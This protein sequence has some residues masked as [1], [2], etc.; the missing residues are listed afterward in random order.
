MKL[1]VSNIFRFVAIIGTLCLVQSSPVKVS[2]PQAITAA[3][4]TQEQVDTIIQVSPSRA[5]I[6]QQ[7]DQFLPPSIPLYLPDPERNKS[8][9]DFYLLTAYPRDDEKSDDTPVKVPLSLD[10]YVRPPPLPSLDSSPI[11][12]QVEQAEKEKSSYS[13]NNRYD[14]YF[15]VKVVYDDNQKYA[16]KE[17][18]LMEM[19][20]PSFQSD[21]PNYYEIKPKKVPKKYQPNKKDVNHSKSYGRDD[22]NGDRLVPIDNDGLV[23]D[24]E[25]TPFVTS[26]PVE[27]FA[28]APSYR[29]LTDDDL[30]TGEY[31]PKYKQEQNTEAIQVNIGSSTIAAAGSGKI[32]QTLPHHESGE[33]K[34]NE[35]E[36]EN[37]SRSNGAG[38]DDG[39]NNND[40]DNDDD[41]G[42]DSGT[43][44]TGETS[45]TGK[46]VEFQMHGFK[47][48]NSYKFGYDT[49]LG[50]RDTFSLQFD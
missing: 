27:R 12:F 49:G 6:L 21:E 24:N 4:L 9:D 1:S 11:N 22:E 17:L 2:R 39:E 36:H 8:K 32:V 43:G 18:Q 26:Q 25:H 15:P 19:Q 13:Y 10:S 40:D 7:S 50:T 48:P 47:G 30:N 5:S 45:E 3:N 37:D 33:S 31:I 14:Y 28:P 42:S 41:Q 20:P 44:G 46:R 29:D 23:L 16:E 34:S 38:D 35:H